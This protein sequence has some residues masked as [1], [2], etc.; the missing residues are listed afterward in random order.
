MPAR[1]CSR[2]D[3]R[4]QGRAQRANFLLSSGDRCDPTNWTKHSVNSRCEIKQFSDHGQATSSDV[5][6]EVP[7]RG[8][9]ARHRDQVSGKGPLSLT[10]RV[11]ARTA[12]PSGLGQKGEGGPPTKTR[13]QGNTH[14][15]SPVP[16][17]TFSNCNP[18]ISYEA[19]NLS[20]DARWL[21]RSSLDRRPFPLE[22]LELI[23]NDS[24]IRSGF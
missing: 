16:P 23:T 5:I 10:G 9:G 17:R 13:L 3:T 6:S 4:R 24:L 18:L 8:K 12:A 19:Q 15:T 11:E 7:K 21:G 2:G 1:R 14:Q 20:V 22:Y